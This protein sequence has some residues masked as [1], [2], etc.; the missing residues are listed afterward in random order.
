LEVILVLPA[1]VLEI[2]SLF[3]L[4]KRTR[5]KHIRSNT[6]TSL[7]IP[8]INQLMF[9]LLEMVTTTEATQ[10]LLVANGV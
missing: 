5:K 7:L 4:D 8:F 10:N 1:L 3:L 9:N 2:P 6:S